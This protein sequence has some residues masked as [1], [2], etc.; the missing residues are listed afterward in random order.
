MGVELVGVKD[1]EVL[2]EVGGVGGREGV[3]WWRRGGRGWGCGRVGG[4]GRE[5]LGGG[6]GVGEGEGEVEEVVGLEGEVA[7]GE[8]ADEVGGVVD[9]GVG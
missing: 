5:G 2:K 1:G 9:V 4:V 3:G 6:E 8:G 7:V